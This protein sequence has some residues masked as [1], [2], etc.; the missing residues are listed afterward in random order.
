MPG[1]YR[2]T[3]H[4][5]SGCDSVV[6]EVDLMLQD[7]TIQSTTA[8]VCAGS[9]YSLPWGLIVNTSGIFSDT[10]HYVS[11]CDSLIRTVLLNV[12]S[13]SQET[14]NVSICSGAFYILPW[15]GTVTTA[16]LYSDTLSYPGGCD[17][18]IK[19]INLVV[20]PSVNQTTSATFCEGSGYSLPW[21]IVV[22]DGGIYTDT[23]YHNSGCDSLIRI[24]QLTKQIK[25]TTTNAVAI[26]QG[27][28]FVLPWGVTVTSS[29]TYTNT[30]F[31]ASGC[32]SITRI[33]TVDVK[34]LFNQTINANTCSGIPY[35]L[36]WGSLATSTGIY[37]DTIRYINGCD[38][39]R[40]TVN[41][42]VTAAAISNT[43]A[44]IC[45]NETFTL[46][47]GPT[48]NT[49]GVYTDTVK[50]AFGCDSLVRR[51]DLTVNPNPVVNL[52]KSND[53]D[54]MLGT[55]RL[56]ASGGQKY[57]W[58]PAATLDKPFAY[59]PVAMPT[60]TTMYHVKV[61]SVN[62][63]ITEDSIL[64]NVNLGDAAHGYLVASAFTPNGD[65]KNDCFGVR[66]WGSVT[67]LKFSIFSRWGELVF[68]TSNPQICWDGRYK[69]RELG[70]E[71]FVYVITAN[72]ICGPITRKG[73]VTVIR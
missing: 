25:S 27:A 15:G 31:Y 61:S 43:N 47:W 40:R 57:E 67:D 59:N 73:T 12:R 51:V 36:P 46:P 48:V 34:P 16:G 64:V 50:T 29:G 71:V 68:S 19:T 8:T 60:T 17:S 62:N 18:L 72:T 52:Q 41:L 39:L 9:S 20:Q 63:C 24:V 33:Y 21:G 26:C 56:T 14:N 30:L 23:L 3:L 35:V 37:R 38:S 65:G 44:K 2:D 28:S 42:N 22:S 49:S 7:V 55:A 66:H 45:S 70:S 10:L 1:I 58:S 69:S 5:T 53:I 54:C 32:D 13:V 6:F 11:G 4:Y